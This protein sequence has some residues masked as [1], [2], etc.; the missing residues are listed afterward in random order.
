MVENILAALIEVD[1]AN[2]AVYQANAERYLQELTTLDQSFRDMM[3]G[4]VRHTIY[5]AGRLAVHYL[6][7]EYGIDYVAAPMETEPSVALVAEMMT[8]IQE[9]QIP[10][11]FYEELVQPRIAQMIAEESGAEALLLHSVHNVANDEKEKSYVDFMK[12]NVENLRRALFP[13]K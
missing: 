1:P 3:K 2:Q 12:Q 11:I 9:Q 10:V 13:G 7:H 6:L 4:A 5:H 8:E